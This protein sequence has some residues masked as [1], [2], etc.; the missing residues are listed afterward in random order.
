MHVK[1]Q[2][3]FVP[4]ALVNV[5]GNAYSRSP[6]GIFGTNSSIRYQQV[7]DA[8]QFSLV[9][10]GGWIWEIEFRPDGAIWP[11]YTYNTTL[12][13]VQVD[14]STTSK[15]PDGLSTAFSENIGPDDNV[16]F[17]GPLKIGDGAVSGPGLIPVRL[18]T[19]FF[20]DPRLGNLLLDV[21]DFQGTSNVFVGPFD[22]ESTTGDSISSVSSAFDEDSVTAV[23]GTTST[24]G[25]YTQFVI[26]VPELSIYS[27]TTP[28][29]YI[30]IEW[31]AEPNFFFLQY[32]THLGTNAVWSSPSNP[33]AVSNS[34]VPYYN[35]YYFPANSQGSAGFYRLLVSPPSL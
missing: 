28:T 3:I 14:L 34:Y 13:N 22:A 8:S 19:P 32:S 35:Q 17:S 25:L 15:G 6:F 9:P 2:T 12:A 26:G 30:A 20:Y 5:E 21:R 31:P 27:A 33:G 4:N 18:S 1:S 23:S 10:R 24:I 11:G 7:Y 16:V 29:N